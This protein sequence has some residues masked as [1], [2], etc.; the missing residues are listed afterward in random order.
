MGGRGRSRQRKGGDS[1]EGRGGGGSWQFVTFFGFQLLQH[2]C[3]LALF[4]VGLRLHVLSQ[5][6]WKERRDSGSAAGQGASAGP[7]LADAVPGWQ[8]VALKTRQGPTGCRGWAGARMSL[9]PGAQA[10]RSP[11]ATIQD[12]TQE[13]G[14]GG[15]GAGRRQRV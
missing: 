9:H 13:L 6:P 8:A 15:E 4:A 5:I 2:P 3:L 12:S 7:G 10:G 14:E 1:E 11:T